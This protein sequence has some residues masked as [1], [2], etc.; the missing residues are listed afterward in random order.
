MFDDTNSYNAPAN[1]PPYSKD[2]TLCDKPNEKKE[3]FHLLVFGGGFV[4]LGFR[5]VLLVCFEDYFCFVWG[6]VFVYMWFRFLFCFLH[7]AF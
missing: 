3:Q 7:S 6:E 4:C 1:K 2:L 5:L